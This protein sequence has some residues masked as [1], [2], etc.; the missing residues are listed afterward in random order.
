MK[1]YSFLALILVLIF[2]CQKEN[3]NPEVDVPPPVDTVKSDIQIEDEPNCPIDVNSYEFDTL[4][5]E[6]LNSEYMYA[7]FKPHETV[8][9]WSYEQYQAGDVEVLIS[10]GQCNGRCNSSTVPESGFGMSCGIVGCWYSYITYIDEDN[11]SHIA[12]DSTTLIS[13]LGEIDTKDEAIFWAYANGYSL[14]YST[15]NPKENGIKEVDSGYEL[16]AYITVG[17]GCGSSVIRTAYHL[18]ICPQ[19]QI[20]IL[21]EEEVYNEIV[22]VCW[23]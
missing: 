22:Y 17:S 9:G 6:I 2:S 13:F 12:N 18:H 23:D 11:A 4:G 20:T 19:G 7:E 10:D 5:F 3:I 8:L 1:K 14:N 15:E 16:R 21:T